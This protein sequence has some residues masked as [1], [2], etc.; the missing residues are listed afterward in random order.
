MDLYQVC[1]NYAPRGKSGPLTDTFI[2]ALNRTHVSDSGLLGALVSNAFIIELTG[3][4]E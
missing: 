3:W 4:K 1:S 2:Y